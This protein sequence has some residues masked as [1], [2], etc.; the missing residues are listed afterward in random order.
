V[1]TH[2]SFKEALVA[3]YDA[4]AS[5]REQRGLRESRADL[6]SRFLQRLRDEERSTLID[7]GAGP[8]HDAVAFSGAG[9]QVT[10]IDLSTQHVALCRAKGIDARVGDFYALDLSAGSFQA[11][12]AMSSLLHVPNRDLDAVVGQIIRVLCPGAPLAIGLWG[13]IDREGIW[14]DDIAAP[15]RFFSLRSDDHLRALLS[16]HFEILEFD[17]SSPEEGLGSNV[18]YQWCVVTAR[19]DAGHTRE[20]QHHRRTPIPPDLGA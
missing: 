18:H 7:L 16:R 13:G 10:A 9:I 12:W 17:V 20:P 3:F 15:R 8:G 2:P 5:E 11:G 14:E 6:R 4:Q 19:S 1:V